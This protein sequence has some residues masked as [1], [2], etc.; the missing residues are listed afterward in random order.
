MFKFL[1][2]YKDKFTVSP[3]A[4]FEVSID[5]ICKKPNKPSNAYPRGDLDNYGKGY[6]DSIT[7]AKLFWEDD[8]QVTK[9]NLTKRYQKEGED[10]GA[11]LS[12]RKLTCPETAETSS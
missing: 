5:I 10:Y 11:Q 6:L 3:K 7:Y 8:I 4:E 9:L 2:G 12:I 1:Q